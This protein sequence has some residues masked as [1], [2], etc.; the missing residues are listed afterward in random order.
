VEDLPINEHVSDDASN[1]GRK[2]KKAGIGIPLQLEV[3]IH[4]SVIDNKEKMELNSTGKIMEF[5]K[6]VLEFAT[7]SEGHT[8]EVRYFNFSY[9]T[10]CTYIIIF[11]IQISMR[12]IHIIL[13]TLWTF[14]FQLCSSDGSYTRKWLKKKNFSI[15][16]KVLGKRSAIFSVIT[17]SQKAVKLLDTPEKLIDYFEKQVGAKKVDRRNRL[18]VRFAIGTCNSSD[19][20]D[21][22][23]ITTCP[24]SVWDETYVFDMPRLLL[25]NE[26]QSNESKDH[27][28]HVEKSIK[29]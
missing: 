7:Y 27:T 3:I 1:N 5:N 25:S 13:L 15:R 12:K 24:S 28:D 18:E 6:S 8:E 21:A 17:P 23:Y 20:I 22:K 26:E 29:T 4:D 2:K 10:C 19:E 9:S 16:N 11:S 14:R